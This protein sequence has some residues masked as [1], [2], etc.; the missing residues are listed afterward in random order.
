MNKKFIRIIIVRE[1]NSQR[2]LSSVKGHHQSILLPLF[3]KVFPKGKCCNPSSQ[4]HISP[5]RDYIYSISEVI[6]LNNDQHQHWEYYKQTT[7]LIERLNN[8]VQL[9]SIGI[10]V[11]EKFCFSK[12]VFGCNFVLLGKQFLCQTD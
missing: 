8:K 5:N 11:S 10:I 6:I 4:Q 12:C 9:L 2:E 3:P 7:V 1:Q